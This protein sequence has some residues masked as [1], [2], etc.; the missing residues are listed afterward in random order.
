MVD[1]SVDHAAGAARRRRERRLRAYLRYAR[2]EIP[3]HGARGQPG[4]GERRE[5][6]L[7]TPWARRLL[8]QGGKHG[9]Y[10]SMDDDADVLAA[11]PTPLVE[12]RPQPGVQRHTAVHIVDILSYVQILDVLVSH[13]GNQVV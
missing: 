11:R 7:T 13:M 4:P 5:T 9:V 2:D 3:P 8:P 10:F 12:V 1:T 6:R